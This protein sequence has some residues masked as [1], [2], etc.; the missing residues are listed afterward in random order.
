MDHNLL[1]YH[2]EEV[3]FLEKY[4]KQKNAELLISLLSLILVFCALVLFTS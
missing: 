4:K 2:Q 1:T 3:F